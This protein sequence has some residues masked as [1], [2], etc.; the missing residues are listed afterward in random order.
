MMQTVAQR[1]AGLT[2]PSGR[3]RSRL[4]I[5]CL[6]VV[7]GFLLVGLGTM[8]APARADAYSTSCQFGAYNLQ[9]GNCQDWGPH[10]WTHG[11]SLI[12]TSFYMPYSCA[13][14][15]NRGAYKCNDAYTDWNFGYAYGYNLYGVA[16]WQCCAAPGNSVFSGDPGLWQWWGGP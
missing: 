8:F 11:Q 3:S 5:L 1:R 7:L 10:N 4:R 16:L 9:W 13:G 2:L 6:A 15:W 14:I 12:R